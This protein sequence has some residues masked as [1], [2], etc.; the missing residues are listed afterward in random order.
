[1]R[2]HHPNGYETLYGHLSRILVHRG[3]HVG[4]GD[5]IGRVGMTGLATGPHLDYRMMKNGAYL[6]PLRVVSPPAEPVAA[7]AA[8]FRRGST[9]AMALLPPLAKTPAPRLEA[10]R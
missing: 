6:N 2:L 9:Q 10:A 7:R 1:V 5:T 8:A 3:Q 4:Q